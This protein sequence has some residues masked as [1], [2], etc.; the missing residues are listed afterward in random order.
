MDQEDRW[1]D[2]K[3]HNIICNL[4]DYRASKDSSGLSESCNHKFCKYQTQSMDKTGDFLRLAVIGKVSALSLK[5]E[6]GKG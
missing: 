2:I 1:N 5:A 6:R 3:W 4:S